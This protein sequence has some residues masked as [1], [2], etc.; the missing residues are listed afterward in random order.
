MKTFEFD[1]YTLLLS[2]DPCDVFIHFRRSGLHG[3][4]M[5]DCMAHENSEHSS[6]IAGLCNVDPETNKPFIYI[7]IKRCTDDVK[8]MGLVM[9]ETSHLYWLL[10]YDNLKDKEEEIITHA[11][12]EA[13]KVVEI[14][15]KF[16]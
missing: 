5:T 9:H 7:N 16:K 12:E 2:D 8:T 13:Y 3:L 15:K 11:E 4:N 1:K 10:N 14:I 6:Y